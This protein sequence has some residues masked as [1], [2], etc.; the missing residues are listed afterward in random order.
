M[1]PRLLLAVSLLLSCLAP[2]AQSQSRA[3]VSSMDFVA[4][5]NNNH[6]EALYYYQNNWAVMRER[7]QAHG[8]IESFQLLQTSADDDAPFHLILITSYPDIE[9]Y[10]NREAN[11]QRIMDK[12][13]GPSFLNDKRPGDFRQVLFSKEAVR[14]LR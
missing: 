13:Q 7:A 10:E 5:L 14:H 6:A 11:F 8:Y 1:M 2:A 12:M 4:V 9:H 3:T